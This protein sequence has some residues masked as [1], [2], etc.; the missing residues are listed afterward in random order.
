MLHV[1]TRDTFRYVSLYVWFDFQ[2]STSLLLS[3]TY[4]Y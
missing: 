4:V 3:C 1:I 2:T